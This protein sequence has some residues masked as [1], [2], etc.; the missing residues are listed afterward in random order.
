MEVPA[1]RTAGISP[2]GPPRGGSFLID[3]A[4]L[5]VTMSVHCLWSAKPIARHS[6]AGRNPVAQ[7]LDFRD[8]V[9]LATRDLRAVSLLDSGLRRNDEQKSRRRLG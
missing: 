9:S 4:L 8:S 7:T 2:Y 6:G 5:R 1:P 3:A